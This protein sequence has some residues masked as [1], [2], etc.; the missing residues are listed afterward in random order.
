MLS[1]QT[2]KLPAPAKI[3]LFLRVI[4]RT[5]MGYHKIQTLFQLLDLCDILT[6]SLTPADKSPGCITAECRAALIE[7]NIVLRAAH[8][9]KQH[10]H[11]S[12]IATSTHTHIQIEKH[13]P[14]GAGLGGGSSNAA[15]TLIALNHLW[16]LN[17]SL[18]ELQTIGASIGADVPVFVSGKNAWAEGIGDQLTTTNLPCPWYL[19]VYPNCPIP[20]KAIFNANELTRDQAPIKFT[21][22]SDSDNASALS[23]K[24][25]CKMV[26]NDCTPVACK[27]FPE[28]EIVLNWLGNYG[29]AYMSGT[30]SSCFVAFD[31]A[32]AAQKAYN[33]LPDKWQ[34]FVTRGVN[35]SPLHT[36]FGI[37]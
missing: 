15:T 2:L 32:K 6:F 1:E 28:V 26:G 33:N 5:R 20:T 12:S 31:D 8:Q 19:V 34:G 22:L 4:K 36:D 13:I 37:H 30:G 27:Q 7:D 9:L 11:T 25:I 24:A 16:Q 10:A 17:L 35:C 23:I 29:L 21:K 3:N 14:L 18:T